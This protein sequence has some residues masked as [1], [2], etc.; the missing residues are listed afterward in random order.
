MNFLNKKNPFI[1]GFAISL[2]AFLISLIGP[3]AT[4]ATVAV[5]FDT[6]G[7]TPVEMV[8]LPGGGKLSSIPTT[9][10]QGYDFEHW[11]KGT[12]VVTSN[13]VFNSNTTVRAVFEQIEYTIVYDT[14]GGNDIES[15]TVAYGDE[16]RLPIPTKVG[17]VFQGW[18]EDVALTIPVTETLE[19]FEDYLLY[20]KWSLIGVDVLSVSY[21]SE[22]FGLIDSVYVAP[23][24]TITLLTPPDREG[25][26][27]VQWING[28]TFT[29]V[30][31]NTFVVTQDIVF[32]ADWISLAGLVT[33]YFDT[34]GGTPIAPIQVPAGSNW[35][36]P[37][38]VPFLA[39]GYQFLNWI[40]NCNFD[41]FE[42][43]C[44]TLN[45]SYVV[46]GDMTV[47]AQYDYMVPLA[48]MRFDS[49]E[50]DGKVLG[51]VLSS[52]EDFTPEETISTLVL[53]ARYSG[54]PVVAI[55][56]GVFENI[57]YIENVIIPEN[58]QYIRER[59]FAN[60]SIKNVYLP[61]SLIQIDY[62]AF[63]G[64][65]L[66]AVHF[67]NN[68]SLR[69][70][71]SSVFRNTQLT[72]FHL[73]ATVTY[74]GNQAFEGSTLSTIT[75]ATPAKLAYLGSETF[76]NT[77]LI[78]VTLPEGLTTIEYEAFANITTLTSLHIP[79]S[80]TAI[81]QKAFQNSTSINVTFGANS[82]LRIIGENLFG[83]DPSGLAFV[84]NA[85]GD[86]VTV[87]PILV[88]Y[89]GARGDNQPLVIPND[90]KIIA[91]NVFNA[92]SPVSKSSLTLPNDLRY[93]GEEAFRGVTIQSGIEFGDGLYLDDR[94]FYEATI[95]GDITF[96]AIAN[97]EYAAFS[98]VVAEDVIF[99]PNPIA[100]DYTIEGEMF[101]F[102]AIQSIT[103]GEG[104]LE[105]PYGFTQNSQVVD[106]SFPDSIQFIDAYAIGSSILETVTFAGTSVIYNISQNALSIE[107]INSP[108]YQAIKPY[109]V[110]KNYLLRLDVSSSLNGMVVSVPDGVKVLG[111][112]VM[113]G[114][115]DFE[116]FDFNDIEYFMGSSFYQW[117]LTFNINQSTTIDNVS[118][119]GNSF[120]S[121][122]NSLI[123]SGLM[124][125]DNNFSVDV[126]FLVQTNNS[127]P[128][129]I[130]SVIPYDAQGFKQLGNV[131]FH[132]DPNNDLTPEEVV[133]DP[134]I[135]IIATYAFQNT[136]LP[137]NFQLNEGL[138]LIEDSAFY[139]TQFANGEVIIPSTVEVIR[140]YAFGYSNL[141]EI[142]IPASVKR[143]NYNA[144]YADTIM[145]V[146]FEDL[147]DIF[148][149]EFAF[150][151]VTERVRDLRAIHKKYLSN[152]MI[153]ID[154]LFVSYLGYDS[155]VNVP[156]GVVSI[157][158]GAF[159]R[160]DSFVRTITL[161]STLKYIHGYAFGS[162]ENLYHI[163]FS[164]VVSLNY[165]G[166]YAF[167]LTS[168]ASLTIDAPI[169]E[170]AKEALRSMP[171]LLTYQLNLLTP[172]HLYLSVRVDLFD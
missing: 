144:F 154:G 31:D 76:A 14:N 116:S 166:S 124:D 135:E 125:I 75:F 69:Y 143:I 54:V 89:K 111:N 74:I 146:T 84:Q 33:I 44:T 102:S 39:D 40:T 150:G 164:S 117:N 82:Q 63:E 42:V 20:A 72:S 21:F 99:E 151:E 12:D 71:R 10:K 121:N 83:E 79:A 127:L 141:V 92:P 134:A 138:K 37:E 105:I 139:G 122:Y 22:G 35:S 24:T 171:S 153:I 52:I 55:G 118:F 53:P 113:Y 172:T 107:V 50:R 159:K 155:H 15:E 85:V 104:Y 73:P 157:A 68:P 51:Y 120:S 90:V 149:D 6:A 28:V 132:Y 60:S 13:T 61:S 25:Y 26:D 156:E 78:A 3:L 59:A 112:N 145:D 65:T 158:S 140:S 32:F 148:V 106:L 131:L 23:N 110:L 133:I 95:Q 5:A 9:S 66:E 27:F 67:A 169:T 108:W 96:G 77:E 56:E 70:I 45:E 86:F 161:P 165:I 101:A 94:A 62:G 100:N 130:M 109:I 91:N 4:P 18:F 98:Y 88:Y 46:T 87:G 29:P 81:Q 119:F 47:L 2:V 38:A 19:V 36:N 49:F 7:G 167:A 8:T 160:R 11:L 43:S 17:A 64:S 162:T 58:I 128:T 126:D 114:W 41:G 93:L 34:Q 123:T 163:D 97:V 1:Y 103:M 168:I 152:N 147:T 129:E 48:K 137:A 136:I 170:I 142:N 30:E 80:V 115:V 57:D 16:V